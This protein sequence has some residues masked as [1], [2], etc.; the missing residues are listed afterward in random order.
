MGAQVSIITSII[1]SIISR[2]IGRAMDRRLL[3]MT[4]FMQ[5][6]QVGKDERE[7]ERIKF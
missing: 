2:G 5:R 1:T 3:G 6:L 4:A 7:D